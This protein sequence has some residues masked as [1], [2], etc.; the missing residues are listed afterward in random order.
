MGQP[1]LTPPMEATCVSVSESDS[2]ED[3][4]LDQGRDNGAGKRA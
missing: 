2:K 1:H 3:K 4:Y